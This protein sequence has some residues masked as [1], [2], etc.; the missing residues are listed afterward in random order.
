M[1]KVE[2][3][4]RKIDDDTTRTAGLEKNLQLS[5]GARVMLKRNKDVEAGLVNGSI[6]SITGFGI[7]HDNEEKKLLALKLNFSIL[8]V[9]CLLSVSHILLKF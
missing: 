4:Y 9:Q 7:R 2:K 3:A 5:V 1:A 8:S 6:G